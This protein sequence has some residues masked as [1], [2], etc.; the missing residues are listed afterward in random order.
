[1]MLG[2]YKYTEAEEKEL[3]SSIVI[4]VDTKEKVNN[5]ITDYFDAHGIPYKKK[6]LQNGDYS[7]YVPKNE[8]L[9]IMRDTYFNDEIFIERKANLEELSA[10]LSAERARFEKEMATA[11]AKKKY[12]LIEN[13][14]YEDVVNGNYD[15][16]YNK[17][18]YLGKEMLKRVENLKNSDTQSKP[19]LKLNP[20]KTNFYDMTIEDF[21]MENYDPIVP[22]LKLELGI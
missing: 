10:N 14:G 19:M 3:L 12:L 18:S 7:F 1:M 5:H 17:K 15:T 4:L 16:Q 2:K 21:S 20:E 9:S 6:A 13:A 11:K 22:Q 8:K